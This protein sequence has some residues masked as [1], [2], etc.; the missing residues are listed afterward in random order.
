MR[1]LSGRGCG[2]DLWCQKSDQRPRQ[3]PRALSFTTGVVPH[4]CP[5]TKSKERPTRESTA[6]IEGPSGEDLL[7]AKRR[8][9]P[10]PPQ[11]L[12]K[13]LSRHLAIDV[14]GSDEKACNWLK[15]PNRALGG[16]VPFELLDTDVGAR[17]VEAAL[18]RVA[19]GIFS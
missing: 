1:D 15:A 3:T 14:L 4:G 16:E 12:P 18:L 2:R 17:Q 11:L 6:D 7:A 8:A 10:N 5:W 9:A 13:R 19:Y